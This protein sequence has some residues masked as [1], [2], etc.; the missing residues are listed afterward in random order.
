VGGRPGCDRT[1]VFAFGDAL[2]RGDIFPRGFS[3]FVM[4]MALVG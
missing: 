2:R 4:D 1:D 3:D